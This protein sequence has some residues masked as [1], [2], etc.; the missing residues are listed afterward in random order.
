MLS[1]FTVSKL[2]ILGRMSKSKFNESALMFKKK[3][4]TVVAFL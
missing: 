1:V 3:K 4:K 2:D